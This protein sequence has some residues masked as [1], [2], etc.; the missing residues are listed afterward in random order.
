[1]LI[2]R[3]PYVSHI[4]FNAG[5]I[6][7]SGIDLLPCF[8][9]LLTNPIAAFTAPTYYLQHTGEITADNL[10]WVWQSNVF[11]HFALVRL[12]HKHSF[13]D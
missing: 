7:F 4:V 10:G 13:P 3:V 6:S 8:K 11:G 1:M 9:Q 12:F 5:V 2:F